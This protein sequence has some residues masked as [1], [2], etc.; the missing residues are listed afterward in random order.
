MVF[1][2]ID[3]D[4]LYELIDK[5]KCGEIEVSMLERIKIL[6][7]ACMGLRKLHKFKI[8]HRDR[9]YFANRIIFKFE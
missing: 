4:S 9:N 3:G 7:K 8:V 6:H 2:Y 5:I 1:E